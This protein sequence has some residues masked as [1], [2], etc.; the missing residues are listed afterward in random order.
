MGYCSDGLIIF[1]YTAPQSGLQIL[2]KSQH[3]VHLSD[4]LTFIFNA[5]YGSDEVAVLPYIVII[6][7][8]WSILLCM[9]QH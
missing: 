4:T 6:Q 5:V 1:K 7:K 2:T 9:R 3:S 8:L